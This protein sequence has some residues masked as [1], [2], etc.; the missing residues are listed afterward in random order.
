VDGFGWVRRI[1]HATW[2]GKLLSQKFWINLHQSTLDEC[3]YAK[4]EKL[5]LLEPET[6]PFWYG[7]ASG[8]NSY[9]RDIY[10]FIRSGQVQLHREDVH[11]LSRQTIHLADGTSIPVQALINATGYSPR[12][13]IQFIPG[14][15]HSD[16][17]IPTRSMTPEQTQ[18]WT[19]LDAKAD[20][21]IRIQ[22][23]RLLRGPFKSPSSN[24]LQPYVKDVDPEIQYTPFRLYRTIAP[25]GLTARGEHS[26]A[27]IGYISN[28]ASTIR[29][30]MQ[31]LWAYAY[32]NDKLNID[33][34]EVIEDAALM[35]RFHKHR[36]PY[37]HGRFFP[38]MVFDQNPFFDLL[39]KDL[40]L[41]TWRKANLL[42][43][44]FEPYGQDDYRGLVQEWLQKDQH[45]KQE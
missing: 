44:V 31:C 11:H 38:D 29:L 41:K 43:E 32:L 12:T 30:E 9:P 42:R 20:S 39:L 40:G 19:V 14:V 33:R 34:S 36:S 13:T 8:T 4:D 37:G 21:T 22:Y 23:P 28:L 10:A 18:M 26:I 7:T 35:S 25:P 5:R 3:G 27:F 45:R 15:L 1:L 16:L 2:L 6:S 17:G 24:V